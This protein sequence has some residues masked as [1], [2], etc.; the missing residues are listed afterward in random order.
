MDELVKKNE[1]KPLPYPVSID[2]LYN[3]L[4]KVIKRGTGFKYVYGL[5]K[6]IAYNLQYLEFLDRCMQD[7]KI[8]NV[9]FS[10]SYKVFI[11][12]GCSIIEALIYYLLIK[13]DLLPGTKW[14]LEFIAKGNEKRIGSKIIKIDSYV[15]KKLPARVLKK[16]ISF[17]KMLDIAEKKKIFGRKSDIYRRLNFLR[18]LRNKVHLH[19]IKSPVDHDWNRFGYD[20]M[21][22]MAK[23][24]YSIF[25][26]GIFRSS[27]EEK[28]YFEYLKKY[29]NEYLST[30]E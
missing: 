21:C 13:N 17:N 28:S 9:I 23:A 26:S 18:K 3:F 29:F 14:E 8:S 25:T 19:L 30:I 16:D 10:I 24:I 11:L 6:N 20:E 1:N 5:R 12:V 15:Y 27:N 7:L 22:A 2:H 4:S